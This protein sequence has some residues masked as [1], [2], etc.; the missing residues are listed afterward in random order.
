[1]QILESHD[2]AAF[3][4]MRAQLHREFVTDISARLGV[5]GRVPSQYFRFVRKT[6]R[7]GAFA[8]FSEKRLGIILNNSTNFVRLGA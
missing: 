6:Y 3:S 2:R 4:T 5:V 1:M 7:L 8:G